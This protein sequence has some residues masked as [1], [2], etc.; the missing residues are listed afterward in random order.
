MTR[1][2]TQIRRANMGDAV[3]APEGEM[4]KSAQKRLLKE[5]EKQKK[6][7]E[8][9]AERA[10]KEAAAPPKAPKAPKA[11]KADGGDDEDEMEPSK[12]KEMREA[13]V[14]QRIASGRT[15]Y[16]HKFHATHS[17]RA[18][19]DEFSSLADGSR[20]TVTAS[21]AG[22]VMLRRESG[23]KL[24]F[25]DL[26]ADGLKVQVMADAATFKGEGDFT[27]EMSAIK[28]GDIIGVRGLPGKSKRGE[29]SIFPTEV[30]MLSPCLHALPK[31][32]LTDKET[33]YR[34]RY[35][36]L[37]VNRN[38]RDI[39]LTR[40][41]AINYLRRYL[42]MLSFIEVETPIL[43]MIPGGATA[44]PFISYHNELQR[45]LYMRIAPELYLKMLVVGGLDRVYEIGRLFRNEGIDLTHN[46]EFTTCEA[47]WAYADYHD[48]MQF[49]EDLL[50]GMVL[51]LTGGYQITIHPE[52]DKSQPGKVIDFTPPFK[53]MPMIKTLEERL[54]IAFP[55]DLENDA[56]MAFLTDL[57][58]VCAPPGTIPPR[59]GMHCL[60]SL[61][62]TGSAGLLPRATICRPRK[63]MPQSR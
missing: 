1:G 29:L 60:A 11:D 33:R 28:R 57:A 23:A 59:P 25:F 15:P 27:T 39:F 62:A 43:N 63:G 50:S 3:A 36:D 61:C 32:G 7:A 41:R 31:R 30:E 56:G 12:F 19:I 48:L 46:P 6:A 2:Q 37:I 4:S 9:A 17:M 21:L 40:T 13:W 45:K 8:K 5:A 55:K 14:R 20:G 24:V 16:P 47:Y 38:V 18:F 34:Q 52:G 26:V 22:R 53:R 42:D 35:L 58:K 54:G 10:A 51:E 44:R 49:T